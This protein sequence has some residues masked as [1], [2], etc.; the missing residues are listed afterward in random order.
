MA[1]CEWCEKDFD[2]AF[3]ADIF[4]ENVSSAYLTYEHIRPCLC[5]ECA[6]KAIDDQIEDVYFETCDH[7]GCEFDY[8]ADAENFLAQQGCYI[9]EMWRNGVLCCDCALEE[10]KGF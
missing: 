8:V 7:C 4:Q 9:T 3:D 5:S 2:P 10:A 6:M 1:V